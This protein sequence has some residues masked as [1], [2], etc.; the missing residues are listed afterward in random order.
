[1]RPRP[2]RL[3]QPGRARRR[4]R[5]SHG[6]GSGAHRDP[7]RVTEW[8]RD[9]VAREGPPPSG[10]RW[11]WEP[12]REAPGVDAH[13]PRA[14][15]GV[16]LRAPARDRGGSTRYERTASPEL[17]EPG[18]RSVHRLSGR[19]PR[20]PVPPRSL[21]RPPET[22]VRDGTRS[23]AGSLRPSRPGRPPPRSADRG[24]PRVGRSVRSGGG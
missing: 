22:S 6:V 8:R 2:S 16:A 10:W 9:H 15:A 14:R 24:S 5:S 13:S 7:G 23:M 17:L 4:G 1:P 21:P 12:A 19:R 11:T 3:V 18:P 20:T